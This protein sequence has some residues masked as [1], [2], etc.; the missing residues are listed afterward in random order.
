MDESKF[1]ECN[2]RL[3]AHVFCS[4]R[5]Q[6]AM[7]TLVDFPART[8]RSARNKSLH[9][10]RFE[11]PNARANHP[12][13]C[14]VPFFF[15]VRAFPSCARV[16]SSRVRASSRGV[17]VLFSATFFARE[18]D[19]RTQTVKKKTFEKPDSG[20][21]PG[22][23]YVFRDSKT[24]RYFTCVIHYETK[25]RRTPHTPHPSDR[26]RHAHPSSKETFV[27]VAHPHRSLTL[28]L[29]RLELSL[30]A[31]LPSRQKDCP[32]VIHIQ[33]ASILVVRSTPGHFNGSRTVD[34]V[35][36]SLRKISKQ[37][38]IAKSAPLFSTFRRFVWF[39]RHNQTRA[40]DERTDDATDD[41][42]DER[43]DVNKRTSASV[44]KSQSWESC[45][46]PK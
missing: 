31:S 17:G 42:T 23:W 20:S 33:K 16:Q 43:T 12:R 7:M 34:L 8:D 37:M 46:H 27:V 10:G 3:C 21:I 45:A 44:L 18:N 2:R 39:V 28:P 38:F 6:R 15:R 40:T 25:R 14:D 26:Q 1:V 36:K 11:S 32:S 22:G 19:R 5:V 35:L 13:V 41:A 24:C 29:S 30:F 9:R 4:P